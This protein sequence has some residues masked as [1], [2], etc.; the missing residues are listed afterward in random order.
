MVTTAIDGPPGRPIIVGLGELLWDVFPDQRRPGGAP[1]NFAWHAAQMG[2]RGLV[3][4]RV[5]VD[6]L[7]DELVEFL[8]SQG[9]DSDFVQRDAEQATSTVSIT[10]TA[11]GQPDYTIHEPVAWDFLEWTGPLAGLFP[12]VAAVCFGTIAQRRPTSR[13]TIN[14][15]LDAM[16]EGALKVYDINLRKASWELATV[17]SSLDRADIV[18]LND[19]EL[20][21]L[22]EGL[23]WIGAGP[24]EI[25]AHLQDRY[26]LDGVWITRGADGCLLRGGDELV[27]CEGIAVE[28][29][30]T[31]GAGDAFTAAMIWAQWVGWPLAESAGLANQVG[32]LVASRPG[33]MPDLSDRLPALIGN[34][35]WCAS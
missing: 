4:S 33:G 12:G 14:A 6:S 29:A 1:A 8:D 2:A 32:A 23:D 9:L 3:V 10:T 26:R 7:G 19:E 25:A 35:P 16:P 24:A 30:D 13:A 18:K 34:G 17:E 11:D 20:G 15:C 21:V 22:A 27:E 5:G 28:V 31:V